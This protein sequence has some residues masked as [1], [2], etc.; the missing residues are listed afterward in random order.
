VVPPS[1]AASSPPSRRAP[2]KALTAFLH[3]DVEQ[4]ELPNRLFAQGACSR[5]GHTVILESAE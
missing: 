5:R 4:I 2:G 1:R 3:D